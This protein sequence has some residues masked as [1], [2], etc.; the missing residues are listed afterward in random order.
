MQWN[1]VCGSWTTKGE[2]QCDSQCPEALSV[3]S[4]VLFWF[5]LSCALSLSLSP[6]PSDTSNL[7]PIEQRIVLHTHEEN[8]TT[9]NTKATISIIEM[10]AAPCHP[11]TCAGQVDHLHK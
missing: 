7:E 8:A 6:A 2:C 1:V 5:Y 3:D 9:E 4:A 11:R 10:K